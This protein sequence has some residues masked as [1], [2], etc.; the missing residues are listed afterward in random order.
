[1]AT[2]VDDPVI[3]GHGESFFGAVMSE[4]AVRTKEAITAAA[5]KRLRRIIG[6]SPDMWGGVL[7]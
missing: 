4:Q 7:R 6:V 2:Q 5:M 3:I 1:L